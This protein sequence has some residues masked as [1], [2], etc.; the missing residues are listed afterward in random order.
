MTNKPVKINDQVTQ[1]LLQHQFDQRKQQ[2]LMS[3]FKPGMDM[4][5][6]EFEEAMELDRIL[7]EERRQQALQFFQ[8]KSENN[9]TNYL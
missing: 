7:E 2:Q 8:S 9:Y 3:K 5:Q 6:R 1:E 4:K